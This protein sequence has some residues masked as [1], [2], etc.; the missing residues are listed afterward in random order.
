MRKK[1]YFS[2]PR[3]IYI[4]ISLYPLTNIHT[5]KH[6]WAHTA[7]TQ[8]GIRQNYLTKIQ[9]ICIFLIILLP[10][11]CMILS[12][13][14]DLSF[15]L[16]ICKWGHFFQDPKLMVLWIMFFLFQGIS[17]HLCS[18]QIFEI[19]SKLNNHSTWKNSNTAHLGCS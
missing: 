10:T 6:T 11:A 17:F 13:V 14:T 2:P 19:R 9:Q 18:I 4:L 12:K 1:Q 8:S 15:S 3:P 16:F 7:H 5:Y